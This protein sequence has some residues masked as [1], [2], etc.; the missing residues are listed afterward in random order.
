[1]ESNE[2]IAGSGSSAATGEP[3]LARIAPWGFLLAAVVVFAGV[4]SQ[5]Y[6]ARYM[7][8][9]LFHSDAPVP[10]G[11]ARR[12]VS[13]DKM[14]LLE[15]DTS[16]PTAA[17]RQR[18]IWEKNPTNKVYF[19]N[20]I[21]CLAQGLASVKPDLA[22]FEKEIRQGETLDPD[23]GAYPARLGAEL[24]SRAVEVREDAKT[25]KF[26][27]TVKDRALLD[28]GMAELK[29]VPG[30]SVFRKYVREMLAE[31][32]A[33]LPEVDTFRGQM[34]RLSVA[35]ASPVPRFL[36]YRN[37]AY[38]IPAYARLLAAEGKKDE[39][40]AVL[41]LWRPLAVGLGNDAFTLIETG[42]AGMMFKIAG[43][44]CAPVY[45]ELGLADK[46]AEVRKQSDAVVAVL[47]PPLDSGRADTFS[48]KV[49]EHGGILAKM[50]VPGVSRFGKVTLD[51]EALAA[52][53]WKEYVL[54]EQ[55]A[56]CVFLCLV[57]AIAVVMFVLAAIRRTGAE[58]VWG[59]PSFGEIVR[60][61]GLA[62]VLPMGLYFVYSRFLPFSGREHGLAPGRFMIEVFILAG[63]VLGVMGLLVRRGCDRAA[64]GRRL[65]LLYAMTV[66]LV[67]VVAGPYLRQAEHKFVLRD[68]IVGV[69]DSGGFTCF[70][71]D[72]VRSLKADFA[73]AI[74]GGAVEPK[75]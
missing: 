66:I 1:M 51:D 59:M 26:T 56:L 14:F 13:P 72:I 35:A 57:L 32:L 74:A 75:K 18:A 4:V 63:A 49:M 15:G 27:V 47:L 17:A 30:K 43:Q 54:A 44:E 58:G 61:L 12:I 67:G 38:A 16:R 21:A 48:Q 10:E 53:R 70:E 64:V 36:T 50:V 24:V 41:D 39:A 23:N 20:Y 65:V 11:E 7:V 55:V 9:A 71:T 8:W 60:V 73:K 62:V 5:F 29:K 25:K 22:L 6:S 34:I 42:T 19:G 31:R 2:K 68:T 28:L 40:A 52:S 37:T 46:A 69:D 45:E 33:A 3:G